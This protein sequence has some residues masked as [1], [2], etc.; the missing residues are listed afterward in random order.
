L[1]VIVNAQR[2]IAGDI[3]RSVADGIAARI[4]GSRLAIAAALA[5]GP[6]P[7]DPARVEG[8]IEAG[9]G[10]IV[11]IDVQ[12]EPVAGSYS[13]VAY[14]GPSMAMLFLFFTAGTGARSL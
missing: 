3:A 7:P 2:R 14:F 11:P 8:V 6:Q 10:L 4:N 9:K 5:A 1:V 13:P 12:Q